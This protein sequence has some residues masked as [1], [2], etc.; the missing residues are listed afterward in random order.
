MGKKRTRPADADPAVD[1]KMDADADSSSD[2]VRTQ[3]L[4]D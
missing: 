2:E 4:R 1:N 3:R